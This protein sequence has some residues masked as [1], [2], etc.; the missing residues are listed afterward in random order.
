[1]TQIE[2][3]TIAKDSVKK[4]KTQRRRQKIPSLSVMTQ[5]DVDVLWLGVTRNV[6]GSQGMNTPS[7]T[8]SYDWWIGTV[9]RGS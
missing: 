8:M 3:K 2:W 5:L 4:A 1:M 9:E 7:Q 6:P